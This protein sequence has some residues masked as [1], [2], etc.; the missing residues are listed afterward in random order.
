MN[1]N[2]TRP[3]GGSEGGVTTPRIDVDAFIAKYGVENKLTKDV[4]HEFPTLCYL[5]G[6]TTDAPQAIDLR[7]DGVERN[8]FFLTEGSGMFGLTKPE[9]AMRWKGIFNHVMGTTRQVYYLARKL[10][11]IDESGKEVFGNLGF[12][13]STFGEIDPE[14]MQRFFFVSHAG[15]RRSDERAWHGLND[16]VHAVD[17][18]GEASLQYLIDQDAEQGIIDLMR[19]ENH[20]DLLDTTKNL[21][22]FPNIVDNVLTYTDW[23]YGQRP[24]TLQSR[25]EG[26]RKSQRQP[27]DI[28]DTLERAGNHFEQALLEA[29]GVDTPSAMANAAYGWEERIRRA[30]C[31]PSGISIAQTFPDYCTQF[32]IAA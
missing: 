27:A 3:G 26:L 10:I 32:G 15:R 7:P 20:S 8:V 30:Y 18:I 9:D 14:L 21:G 23:T 4:L 31:A 17:D 6:N 29:V 25:Y 5:L 19:V 13:T 12:D 16:T 2:E 24:Q 11:E 22:H 1:I 28:L